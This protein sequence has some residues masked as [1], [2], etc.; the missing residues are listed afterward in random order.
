M[1]TIQTFD[2]LLSL[3]ESPKDLSAALGVP[4]VNAQLMKHRKSVGLNHWP[5]LIAAAGEKGIQL[6]TDDLLAMRSRTRE[7][8]AA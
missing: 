8:S 6:T 7:A 1:N 3:W 5:R 4:Y 2:D